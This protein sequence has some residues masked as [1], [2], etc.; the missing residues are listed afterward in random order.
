MTPFLSGNAPAN[1]RFFSHQQ[2]HSHRSRSLFFKLLGVIVLTLV[3]VNVTVFL[4]WKHAFRQDERVKAESHL[5]RYGQFLLSSLPSPLDS[6]AAAAFSKSNDLEVAKLSREGAVYSDG[7]RKLLRKL[8]NGRWW[9]RET[10]AALAQGQ[11]KLFWKRGIG[12]ILRVEGTDTTV[13]LH[14]MHPTFPAHHA[15]LGLLTTLTVLMVFSALGV[16]HFLKPMRR[17]EK[18]VR[19][20]EGG[21]L[22]FRL[23]TKG[24]DEVA[25]IAAS[26]NAMAESIQKRIQSRDQ[27]LRD[28]SHEFRSPLTRLRVAAE[29]LPTGNLRS[30]VLEDISI[31]ESMVQEI[32]ESERL[33]SPAGGLK[34]DRVDLPTLIQSVVSDFDNRGPGL[35]VTVGSAAMVFEGDEDRLRIALRNLIDNA[36]KYSANQSEP[37]HISLAENGPYWTLRIR[38]RGPGIPHAERERIF[39]PFYRIDKARTMGQGFGLGLAL[40]K[41]I[42]DA[43]AIPLSIEDNPEPGT[44]FRLDF[45]ASP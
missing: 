12:G 14:S 7:A 41:R 18:G 19:A 35:R 5:L 42:C 32:L 39:E 3:A 8:G 25:R 9:E 28:V 6:S 20:I 43:H 45:S 24:H 37:V 15:L 2:G 21:Q 36:L 40:V 27:L 26:F 13:L 33:A 16:H 10:Q 11:T 34:R 4:F 44:T 22:D 1:Q 30:D 17:L 29:M 38:D 23:E 31:L